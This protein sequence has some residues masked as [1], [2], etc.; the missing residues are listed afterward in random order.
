MIPRLRLPAPCD[1]AAYLEHHS[2]LFAATDLIAAWVYAAMVAPGLVV[3]LLAASVM[4]HLWA[5]GVQGCVLL[6]ATTTP[7][8]LLHLGLL[9]TLAPARYSAIRLPLVTA[10]RLLYL[11]SSAAG[12]GTCSSV[13][14]WGE[15]QP[16]GSCGAAPTTESPFS[17]LLWRTGLISLVWHAAAF[18]LPF[19]RHLALQAAAAVACAL[20]LAEPACL[21][22]PAQ[23]AVAWLGD[24]GTV[25]EQMLAVALIAGSSVAEA[26]LEALVQ[27]SGPTPPGS[28]SPLCLMSVRALVLL[29]GGVGVSA[30]IYYAE[31]ADRRQWWDA[32]LQAAD[33]PPRQA[34]PERHDEH[35][36]G[37]AP[38]MAQQQP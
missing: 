19:N 6:T 38:T 7:V 24:A 36:D 9:H 3:L 35:H 18:R 22:A 28:A 37:A 33:T 20:L 25:L 26:Q 4:P 2:R 14:S 5:P 32:R 11:L 34:S 21:S 1:E 30:L 12:L 31:A 13:T 16:G 23:A 8:L 29:L 27:D 10:L 15:Q 17:A